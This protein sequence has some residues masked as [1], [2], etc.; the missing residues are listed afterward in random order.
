MIRAPEV[1]P[2]CRSQNNCWHFGNGKCNYLHVWCPKADTCENNNCPWT[3]T[4]KWKERVARRK[5]ASRQ[6]NLL[7]KF[8]RTKYKY[9]SYISF[10]NI[11]V[12]KYGTI[13]QVVV[14]SDFV[15]DSIYNQLTQIFDSRFALNN[16]NIVKY[17]LIRSRRKIEVQCEYI[18]PLRRL[19]LLFGGINEFSKACLYLILT[20]LDNLEPAFKSIIA[21]NQ[22]HFRDKIHGIDKRRFQGLLGAHPLKLAD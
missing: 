21:Y 6:A 17:L 2:M 3:H 18:I 19:M 1:P 8:Q 5:W 4:N 9:I 7:S 10:S 20:F 22:R 13:R 11:I 16:R 12:F 15:G 14:G